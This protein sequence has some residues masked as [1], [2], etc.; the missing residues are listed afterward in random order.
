MTSPESSGPTPHAA[1]TDPVAL[2]RSGQY[3]RLL[4][5]AAALGAPISAVAY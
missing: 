3:L 5:V 2:L 1:P 4:V